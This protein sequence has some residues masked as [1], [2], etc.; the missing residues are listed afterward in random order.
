MISY[1]QHLI[2][3]ND[4]ISDDEILQVTFWVTNLIMQWAAVTT[5]VELM[6]EPPQMCPPLTRSDT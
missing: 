1:L 5:Y 2:R 3:A 6:M 4:T